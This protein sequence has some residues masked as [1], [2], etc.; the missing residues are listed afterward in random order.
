MTPERI[1]ELEAELTHWE[2]NGQSSGVEGPWSASECYEMLNALTAERTAREAAE[3]ELAHVRHQL[4][5][6][7]WRRD[8]DR[9][10]VPTALADRDYARKELAAAQARELEWQA[11]CA[12]IEAELK[13]S[14]FIPR[15]DAAGHLVGE[16]VAHLHTKKRLAR[17]TEALREIKRWASLGSDQEA[18][19]AMGAPSNDT[20]LLAIGGMADAALAEH[21]SGDKEGSGHDVQWHGDFRG[22]EDDPRECG[23]CVTCDREVYDGDGQHTADPTATGKGEKSP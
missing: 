20:V 4:K 15:E 13:A 12:S 3:R 5:A 18:W 10:S 11:R 14:R 9:Q 23:W 1:A 7:S 6:E 22:T 16:R 8:C 17:V 19:T 2:T 21:A